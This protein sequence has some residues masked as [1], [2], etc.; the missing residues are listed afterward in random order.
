[1]NELAQVLSIFIFAQ[2]EDEL[3]RQGHN[4]TGSL[5]KSFSVQVEEQDDRVVIS[6]LMNDYGL[7]LEYGI[8]HNKIPYTPGGGRGGTSKYIQGL[9]DFARKRFKADK[10]RAK[11]I[12]FA[13]ANKQKRDGYPLTKKIGFMS[14]VLDA[15][16]EAIANIVADQFEAMI[17]L[18]IKE[19]LTY[20]QK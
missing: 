5:V 2:L 18:L 4:L 8:K 17:E 6:F 20:K 12:A 9:M 3:L 16:K 7:S 13:I 10:R 11:Q 15:D 19:Y 14:N 1:M